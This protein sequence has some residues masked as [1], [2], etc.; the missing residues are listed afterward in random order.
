VKALET[1]TRIS[2]K[3]GSALPGSHC[4][5]LSER[6]P[7]WGRTRGKA[8]RGGDSGLQ[9]RIL[10]SHRLPRLNRRPAGLFSVYVSSEATRIIEAQNPA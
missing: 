2:L 1:V 3:S 4:T 8:A 7:K 6:C 9:P 5:R 10:R